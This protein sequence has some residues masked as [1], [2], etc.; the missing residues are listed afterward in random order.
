LICALTFGGGLALAAN[1]VLAQ[2]KASDGPQEARSAMADG[3]GSAATSS[4]R[5]KYAYFEPANFDELPGWH[6]DQFGDAWVAFRQSC[7]ALRKRSAWEGPC[8]RSARIEGSSDEA[9]RQ[10]FEQEFNLYQIHNTDRT[11][12]G[13]V[14]GYYEP[15]LT[16]SRRFGAPY[17]YPVYAVP[18]DLLYL[19]ARTLP[20]EKNDEIRVR[21]DGRNVNVI[22]SAPSDA[23]GSGIYRL[24]IA[25]VQPDIR[26]RRYRLR[27]DGDRVVPY[28]SRQEIDKGQM[29]RAKVIVWV[30]N[31]AALYSMQIQGSGKIRLPDGEVIRVAYGEQNGRPFQP[32]LQ[33]LPQQI[34]SKG[35]RQ[36]IATRGLAPVQLRDEAA[37]TGA[38]EEALEPASS[39]ALPEPRTRG[40][41]RPP[42]PQQT[43]PFELERVIE[44]LLPA[45]GRTAIQTPDSPHPIAP[46]VPQQPKSKIKTAPAAPNAQREQVKEQFASPMPVPGSIPV[47]IPNS[48]PSYVFFRQIPDNDSGPIGALGVPLTAGRSVAVDPRTT[49][50]GFPVF[51]STRQ[52]GRTAPLNRLM[53][54]QDTGGAIS[55]AVRA[56]YFW[57]FGASAFVQA[58][59][60]KEDGRM[61]LLLPKSQKIAANAAGTLLRGVG[62]QGRDATPAECVVPDPELCVE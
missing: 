7:T 34:D 43:D 16:G 47:A 12:A 41:R 40:M 53:L 5:T 38:S 62:G 10:F 25:G 18:D 42:L 57:G 36:V 19:D 50:L 13:L 59:R 49:P 1:V 4:F 55:G 60:M 27:I 14:T 61:W 9:L 3:A 15:L 44:A 23:T 31:P 6:D 45:S 39:S 17:G 58:S 33:A 35:K 21:V 24:D 2:A 8:A 29:M 51:I 48:D 20:T 26:T 46:D 37:S 54:A 11:P 32:S 22:P 52:P 56:D 28:F 30:D